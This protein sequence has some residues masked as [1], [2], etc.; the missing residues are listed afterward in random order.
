MQLWRN[1]ILLATKSCN[2]TFHIAPQDLSWTAREKI[3]QQCF[4]AHGEVTRL[5]TVRRYYS[6][7]S[8]GWCLG[9]YLGASY[10]QERGATLLHV[11]KRQQ[12]EKAITAVQAC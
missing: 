8:V 4:K 9:P 6:G 7:A 3:V 12:E 1:I 5:Q 2:K 11:I 10:Q